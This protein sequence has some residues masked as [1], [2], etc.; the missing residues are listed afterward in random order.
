MFKD[1]I[2][3]KIF[4][5]DVVFYEIVVISIGNRNVLFSKRI[6]EKN[7]ETQHVPK[8]MVCID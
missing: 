4:P 6:N 7:N 3:F 5:C 1:T 2:F 8:N